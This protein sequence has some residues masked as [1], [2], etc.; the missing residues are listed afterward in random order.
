M[1]LVHKF[2]LGIIFIVLISSLTGYFAIIQTKKILHK[3]F[4]SSSET[5]ALDMLNGLD[6]ELTKIV[7]E[8]HGYTQNARLQQS[9]IASNKEFDK[10]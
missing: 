3:A 8:F 9:L 7:N 1:K 6:K 5:L 4:I 10:L 2:I